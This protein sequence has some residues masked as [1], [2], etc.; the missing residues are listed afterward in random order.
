[1]LDF[2]KEGKFYSA[3]LKYL[4]TMIK[5]LLAFLFM[6]CVVTFTTA[7][8]TILDFETPG[9]STTFQ[10]FGSTIDGSLNQV[11]ANPNP[12][13]ENTSSMVAE[14]IK[15]AVAETWAGCFSNPNPA[16][17]VE[18]IS[19]GKVSI[20]VH[21]DHIGNVGLKLEGS[22]DGGD[23]WFL[24][25]PN[26]KVNEWETLVFDASQL[27]LDPPNTAALG[28]TYARVTL[29]FDFG[30]AGTGTDVAYYFDDIRALPNAPAPVVILDFEAPATSTV[31]QY[32]GSPLDGTFTS[33]IA[34]PNATGINT[35]SMVTQYVK[36]AVSET[37]AGCFSNP[38]PETLVDLIGNNMVAINVHM[39]HIGSVSLKLE[40]SIDGGDNWVVTVPNTKVNEWETLVFDPTLPSIEAPFTT[41]I[42][43]T[44]ARVVLFFDFG[45]AGTGVDVTSYFDDI[46]ALPIGEVV[47]TVLDF[48]APETSTG[49]QYF[50][51][52]QDG[53]LNN[54]VANPNPTG[55][56]TSANVSDYVKP[57]V[58]EVW[59]G[60][61]SNPAPT[62]P[63]DLGT[64]GQICVKVHMDHIGN[65]ALKL[66]GS[67]SGN[68]NWITTVA[69]TKVGEW[70][71]ICFDSSVPS[72]EAPF[73][74]ASG[75]YTTIVLFFDF[76]TPGTGTDVTSYF[77]DIVTKG[78]GAPQPRTINFKVDMNQYSDN[79]DQVYLSGEFNNWSGDAN[80]LAD[81][82]FDGIW[83]GSIT[84][85]N[86]AYEYK[87]T[88]DNWLGQESFIGT[89]ECTKRDPSGQFV[90][91]LLTVSADRDVPVF[92]YN[93]CYECG[94]EVMITFRLG[95]GDTIPNPDGVWLAG[96]GNFD[97]PG[98]KYQMHDDDLDG[99]YEVQVPR[100][101]NFSSFYA[102]ANGPCP[103]Y[104]CKEDLTGQSCGDPNNFNDRFL[105][106]VEVDTEVSNCY[107]SCLDATCTTSTIT[108]QKDAMVF[109]LN[110]NP[111]GN[112]YS[113]LDFGDDRNTEKYI[114]LSNSLGQ[115][116]R[117]WVVADGSSTFEIQT[118]DLQA[119][120]YLV[121]VKVGNRFYTRKLVH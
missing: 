40:G 43:H 80:P 113:V 92:C 52:P 10:Y 96:G 8:T 49:F 56:N 76:G 101:R 100:R 88:L 14:Y 105:P 98:G 5:N 47:T 93:S 25:Q 45:T 60:A 89:E 38:N 4:N 13:G 78:S 21:M 23:N 27:S 103:D 35:S 73:E 48:E 121:T 116:I 82:E 110:G 97:V 65:L 51:S 70:E 50:G 15:P 18:L 12:T 69:N 108:P 58:A 62:T 54:I 46:V 7:Q 74:A 53:S 63:I 102:Y 31:F 30:T 119:G 106:A 17:A 6:V 81:P 86:G 72:V 3:F 16:T 11:I 68:P 95:M 2:L 84:V 19:N 107:E 57:A 61:F 94:E 79:F 22:T 24:T 59:A 28:H 44:Y 29:F 115:V 55:I 90:N 36:P 1:M 9:T 120:I 83:E 111:S 104:S 77:D 75:T 34:N 112:G 118:S 91:R 85:P 64:G 32:F 33:V 117:Q 66:E 26:T 20:K 109:N 37:W 114:T 87:V 41:A 71:E 99:V 39:D 67:T 42:G